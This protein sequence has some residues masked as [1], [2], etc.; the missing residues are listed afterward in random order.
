VNQEVYS[1]ASTTEASG[2]FSLFRRGKLIQT[3]QGRLTERG[4]RPDTFWIQR[5]QS[6][7]KSE[8]AQFDWN[9]G[10]ILYGSGQAHKSAAMAGEPQDL[11][12]FLYQFAFLVDKQQDLPFTIVNGRKVENYAYQV[13][14]E[15][16]LE[17]PVGKLRTLKVARRGQPGEDQTEVW[18]ALDKFHWPVKIR[19]TDKNGD[20]AIQLIS[21]IK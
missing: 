1:L 21:E 12:S 19:H 17:T 20:V 4:F 9:G 16:M 10:K 15:E 11:L 7:E 18:L 3:S 14:G 5:G 8:W 6:V 13:K 2:I